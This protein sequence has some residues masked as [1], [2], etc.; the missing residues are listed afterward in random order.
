MSKE[1]VQA[2]CQKAADAVEAKDAMLFSQAASNVANAMCT[3][4]DVELKPNTSI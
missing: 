3:L 1:N 4:K 2:L